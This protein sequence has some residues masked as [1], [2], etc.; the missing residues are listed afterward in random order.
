MLIKINDVPLDIYPDEFV[1]TILDLDD[2]DTS[3]RTSDAS[4]YR[5]RIGVK[6]QIQVA[7]SLI[8]GATLSALL[9]AMEDIEFDVYYPDTFLNAYTTKNFYVGDRPATFKMESN[10][11]LYWS[12]FAFTLTEN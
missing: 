6:R 1:V 11:V 12:N 10:G 7:Y 5:D 9:T 3:T 8:D 2:G 4:M